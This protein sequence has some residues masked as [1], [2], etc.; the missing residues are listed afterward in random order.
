MDLVLEVADRH[1]LTPY[2]YPAGWPETE[3]CRQLLSL[4]VI[5]NVGALAVYLLCATLSYHFIFDHQLM[6]HPQF[7]EVRAPAAPVAC[8]RDARPPGSRGTGP[9]AR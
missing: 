7:L 3:P 4:F 2:V 5:T 9:A 8:R 1:L 6:K